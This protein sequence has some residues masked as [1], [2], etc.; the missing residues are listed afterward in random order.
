MRIIPV[1][2]LIGMAGCS[3][4]TPLF[5]TAAPNTRPV[6]GPGYRAQVDQAIAKGVAYLVASQNPD[7]SWG[8][9]LETRG[10]EVYSVIPGTHDGMRA[11]TTSLCVMALREVGEKEAHARGVEFLV[12][13][14]Q[15]RRDTADLLYNIWAHIY[16][17]QALSIEMRSNPDPRIV[18]AVNWHLD[19]LARY[20]TYMGGWNYY[21]FEVGTQVPADQPTSFGT[22][23]GLVALWEAERSGVKLPEKMAERA[24]RRLA[25]MRIPNGSYVYSLG[26]QYVPRMDANMPRGSI[27]RNQACNF[28]LLLWGFGKMDKAKCEAGLEEFEREHNYIQ[29]GRKR[30]LPHSSWYQTAPYYY[31]FGHYY[32][33]LLVEK[34]GEGGRRYG[35]MVASGI[36]PY[37]EAD[38]SWWDYAMW[39]YHKPYGTAYSVMSLLRCR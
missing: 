7:G 13:H 12:E 17:V 28:A 36:L 21:D 1:L 15:A 30:H 18:S 32:A 9:G 31:Y 33:A 2:I 26:L 8:S 35:P 39:D 23:A 19:R 14:G 5:S 4:R 11:A 27:G 3:S 38:G 6:E 10:F 16:V 25:E 37:Q 20:Q 24:L 29:M 34:L 22:A